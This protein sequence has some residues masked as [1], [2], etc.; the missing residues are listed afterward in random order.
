MNYMFPTYINDDTY[1]VFTT[2]VLKYDPHAFKDQDRVFIVLATYDSYGLAT[3]CGDGF[4]I[5]E[6]RSDDGNSPIYQMAKEWETYG[7]VMSTFLAT[8]W[9]GYCCQQLGWNAI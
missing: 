8:Q 7:E 5:E 9:L 4:V 1:G 2:S 6:C 3:P